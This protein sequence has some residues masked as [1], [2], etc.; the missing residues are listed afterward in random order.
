LS[1]IASDGEKALEARKLLNEKKRM[2]KEEF[3]SRVGKEV[4]EK[5]LGKLWTVVSDKNNNATVKRDIKPKEGSSSDT[6]FK[7]CKSSFMKKYY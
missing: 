1:K 6:S 5:G 7:L 3:I 2:S 4:Y